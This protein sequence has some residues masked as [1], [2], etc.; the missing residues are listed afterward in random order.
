MGHKKSR[1]R[2]QVRKDE[3]IR[4]RVTAEQKQILSEVAAR[5]G[6]GVSTWLLMMGLRA[7]QAGPRRS[8]P[9][10]AIDPLDERGLGELAGD[11]N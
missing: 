5:D 2:K 11:S 1:R 9:P 8:D 10:R 4:I 7:A 6:A 3:S